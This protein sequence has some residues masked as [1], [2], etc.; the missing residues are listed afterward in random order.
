[1]KIDINNKLLLK[2]LSGLVAVVLWFAITYTEDPVISQNIGDL[3]MVFEGEAQLRENGLIITNKSKIPNISAVIRGKRSSVISAIGAVEASCDVSRITR[4]GENNVDIKYVYP[5]T[6]TLAKAKTTEV[7]LTTEKIITRSIPIKIDVKNGEKNT[8]FII[9]PKA[10]MEKLIIKGAE[11]DA[12]TISYAEIE[13]DATDMTKGN[14]Q[15]YFYKLY[16]ADGNIVPDDNIIYKSSETISVENTVYKKA[17]LPVNVSLSKE[18]SSDYVMTVKNQS[19]KEVEVGIIVDV[20]VK[21]LTAEVKN[22]TGDTNY[23][24]EIES[25]DVIYLPEQSKKMTAT[26]EILHLAE[27]KIEVDI[28]ILNDTEK[29]AKLEKSRIEVEVKAPENMDISGKIKATVD[30][31]GVTENATLP[32]KIETPDKVFCENEYKVNVYIK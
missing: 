20:G 18:L 16:D 10:P 19:V 17:K 21:S 29:K 15:E 23:E 5:N 4:Q 31:A 24:L 25:P 14:I 32:V 6:V 2:I 9:S 22:V 28:S 13:V 27:K 11:T 1:M 8:E 7:T 3:P 30:V 26:C 12:Y